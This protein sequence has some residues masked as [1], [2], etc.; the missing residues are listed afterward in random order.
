VFTSS[1]QA[2]APVVKIALAVQTVQVLDPKPYAQAMVM[3]MWGSENQ[4]ICLVKL[5]TKESNWNP[6]SRN[7]IKVNGKHAGG[8]PQILGLSIKLHYTKQIDFGLKYIIHRYSTPCEAWDFWL[9]KDEIG[10]GWY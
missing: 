4:Y 3:K 1:A 5:W 8:I 6:K 10:T 2:Q 9:A 7:S